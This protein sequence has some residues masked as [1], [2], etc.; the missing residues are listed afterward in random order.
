MP[1]VKPPELRDAKFDS[2]E[3]GLSKAGS[4]LARIA[5]AN[6]ILVSCIGN[7]G[8]VGL[9]TIPVAFNQQI[10]AVFPNPKIA[11]A[12]FIFYQVLSDVFRERLNAL[13]SGTTVPIVNKSKFNSIKVVLPPI[14]EQKRIVAILDEAFD[15]IATATANTEKNLANA[16][17]L[18]ESYLDSVFTQKGKGWKETT[19]GAVCKFHGGSQPPKSVFTLEGGPGKIRLIQI[20]DYKSDRHI[21]YIPRA[22]ARRFCDE[23]DVMIGRYGPPLFQILRGLTGA[24]NVALMKAAPDQKVLSREYL[25]YFLKNRHILRYII[26]ASNR[27]AGQIGLNKETIEP[28]PIAFPDLSGQATIVDKL[29]GMAE[30]QVVL[31]NIYRMKLAALAELKQSILQKAFAGEL[32]SQPDRALAE[33]IA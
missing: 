30:Q 6:S 20:R 29:E 11:V 8:K 17:E 28:Y 7:L 16:R 21:V 14:P 27:A 13:A 1:L 24:Y 9:N 19:L 33:A 5:P 10:N 31:E 26:H 15:A 25:F 3:D 22:Q 2:A 12:E 23:S 32:T 4:A 18:F